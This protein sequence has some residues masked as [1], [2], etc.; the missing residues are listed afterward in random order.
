MK[1]DTHIHITPPDIIRDYRRIGEKEPYFRLL[2]E[3]PH[4]RF[5]TCEDVVE[6]LAD[7]NFDK[8]VVFGFGFQDMGLCKYVNDYTMEAVKKYP[9]KLI[10]FMVLPVRHKEM[11]KE[12]IRCFDGG[13]RGIGE[14]FPEGQHMEL[15]SLHKTGFKDC[16][17]NYRLPLLLHANETV[18]HYYPGKTTTSINSLETFITNHQ[19]IPIILA[20]FGGGLFFYE[21][22]KEL[23]N[24]FRN[25]YYDTA[26][27]V[28]LYDKAIY[29]VAREIGVLDK[30][31]F[32]TDY[33]LLAISRYED[34]LSTLTETEKSAVQGENAYRLFRDLDILP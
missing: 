28:F 20:H 11:E 25:V 24:S 6:Q 13:L 19:E 23:K 34:S 4:N 3:T 9:D 2:S 15:D 12:I 1:I 29:S 8:G 17:L 16:L 5:A 22:M 26:A 18:G 21:L 30:L 7:N 31:L 27:G 10:G 14:L 32:A 33:P